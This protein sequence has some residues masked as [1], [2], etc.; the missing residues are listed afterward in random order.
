MIDDADRRVA[1]DAAHLRDALGIDQCDL[2]DGTR[3]EILFRDVGQGGA[4]QRQKPGCVGVEA[5]GQHRDGGR[6][7]LVRPQHGGDGIEIRV[8]VAEN[9]V[10][11]P[12]ERLR[13]NCNRQDAKSAKKYLNAKAQSIKERRK[14]V[15]FFAFSPLCA[16]ALHFF[17]TAG[18]WGSP[19][20]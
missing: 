12:S 18:R 2:V 9:D 15:C 6:I 16:F 13:I 7:E 14:G 3:L 5:V 20:A 19:T 1:G 10:H 11:S 17:F 4:V 8:F